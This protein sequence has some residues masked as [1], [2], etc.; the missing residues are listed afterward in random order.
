MNENQTIGEYLSYLRKQNNLSQE[1]LAEKL[2]ISRQAISNWER[3]KTQPDTSTI[4]KLSQIYSISVDEILNLTPPTDNFNKRESST[5]MCKSIY[6]LVFI[7]A[8]LYG[9]YIPIFNNTEYGYLGLV[10]VAVILAMATTVYFIFESIIKNNNFSFVGGYNKVKEFDIL[11]LKQMLYNIE[12]Y[13]LISSLVFNLLSFA[14]TLAGQAT[15]LL[16]IFLFAY[17]INF[18]IYTW[19]INLRNQDEILINTKTIEKSNSF[20][21]MTITVV[22]AVFILTTVFAVAGFSLYLDTE[23]NLIATFHPVPYILVSLL[24]NIVTHIFEVSFVNKCNKNQ[25]AYKTTKIFYFAICT[26]LIIWGALLY[27]FYLNL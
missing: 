8:V 21:L 9:I 15:Y 22:I 24:I 25:V 19:V 20:R 18:L 10:V 2:N 7:S 4:T 16:F 13:F 5:K 6:I 11:K 12:V 3:D 17:I 1:D 27:S 26:N 14:V 23:S